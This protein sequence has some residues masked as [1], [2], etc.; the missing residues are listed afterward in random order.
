[1]ASQTK[2]E[3]P[4]AEGETG[5]EKEVKRP[6]EQEPGAV[7]V[8]EARRLEMHDFDGQPLQNKVAFAAAMT[9]SMILAAGGAA[10]GDAEPFNWLTG[11]SSE[12]VAKDAAMV[13][14]LGAFLDKYETDN[15][16]T[17]YRHAQLS[18]L[19]LIGAPGW[20]DQTAPVRLAYRVFIAT[21]YGAR[22]AVEREAPVEIEAPAA[23]SA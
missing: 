7:E 16:E 19:L 1:M 12:P 5:T 23:A 2:K 6:D 21:W 17:L 20:D 4:R 13:A 11:A 15:P 14:V 22:D 9:A 8:T 18:G 10:I 3:A